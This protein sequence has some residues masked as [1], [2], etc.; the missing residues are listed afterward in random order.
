MPTDSDWHDPE[1]IALEH[2]VIEAERELEAAMT[3][4]TPEAPGPP[5]DYFGNGIDDDETSPASHDAEP[6]PQRNP[7]VRETSD[8]W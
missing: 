3:N 6:S 4:T 8:P 7:V 1:Q 2:D 5:C